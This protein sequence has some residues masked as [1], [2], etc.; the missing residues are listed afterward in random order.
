MTPDSIFSLSTNRS[1]VV[2]QAV[3]LF[4][5]SASEN[6]LLKV[7]I[8]A[9]VK[10]STAAPKTAVLCPAVLTTLTLSLTASANACAL[11]TT[12]A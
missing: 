8:S 5:Q 1:P 6:L 3:Y 11:L 9:C 7:L 2:L 4:G 12:L 10:G